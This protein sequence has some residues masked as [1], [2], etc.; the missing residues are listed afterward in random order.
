MPFLDLEKFLQPI[1]DSEPCGPN[2]EYDAVY[3]EMERA[4][5]GVPEQQY[6]DTII[7][8]K[9]P[10][11]MTVKKSAVELCGRT[12]DLRVLGHLTRAS[13][14]V[15]GLVEFCEILSVIQGLVENF[16]PTLHPQLDP[17]DDNDP[18][19]RVNCLSALCDMPGV[20]APL[21]LTPLVRSRMV[22]AFNRRDIAIAWGEIPKPE[23][24][25]PKDDEE[26][27]ESEKD[28]LPDRQMIEG[29]FQSC[30]HDQLKQFR[31]AAQAGAD[32][33]RNIE[34]AVTREIGAGQ[35]RSLNVLAKE[36][37]GIHKI[38]AEQLKRVASADAPAEEAVEDTG[39]DIAADEAA[40]GGTA[41]A[42]AKRSGGLVQNWNA[43]L[44]TREEA[45]RLLEKVCQYYE[46][47]EPSSPLPLLLRRAMR[48]S[49]KSFLDILFD[50]SPDGLGQAEALGGMTR[51]EYLQM[52]TDQGR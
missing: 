32:A 41:P 33:V 51:E 27:T 9:E 48:L 50:V 42:A 3:T 2:L 35:M 29:A 52:K 46:R 25:P 8:A 45:I 30:D 22:G 4:S 11:W 13:L 19:I 7:P 17:E 18:T 10:D 1:S 15:G 38:L 6:G 37:D 44:Q 24:P 36:L 47:H 31:D 14:K 21:R 12:K 16:W 43:E 28:K 40:A 23:R 39:G 5:Q 34:N 20:I 26:Q 49:S